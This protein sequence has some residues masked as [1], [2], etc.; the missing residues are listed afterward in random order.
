[1]R[2]QTLDLRTTGTIEG[3]VTDAV[4][5]VGPVIVTAANPDA[6]HVWKKSMTLPGP[7]PFMLD[8]LPEGMYGMSAYPG[9]R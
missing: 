2:F 3:K 4:Q 6:T 1:M 8:R 7:G 9:C 5:G